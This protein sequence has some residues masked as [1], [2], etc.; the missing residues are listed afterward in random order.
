MFGPVLNDETVL[1]Q[2]LAYFKTLEVPNSNSFLGIYEDNN[3]PGFNALE[4]PSHSATSDLPAQPGSSRTLHSSPIV[5]FARGSDF[6]HSDSTRGT[7]TGTCVQHKPG[8]PPHPVVHDFNAL[9]QS[10]FILPGEAHSPYRSILPTPSPVTSIPTGHPSSGL[11]HSQQLPP[12]SLSHPPSSCFVKNTFDGRN[13]KYDIR[14]NLDGEFSMDCASNLLGPTTEV[15]RFAEIGQ[16]FNSTEPRFGMVHIPLESTR[17]TSEDDTSPLHIGALKIGHSNRQSGSISAD[18]RAAKLPS[19][20]SDPAA[21]EKTRASSRRVRKR[22]RSRS[23]AKM[24]DEVRAAHSNS[25]FFIK[26]SPKSHTPTFKVAHSPRETMT[27]LPASS[28]TAYIK[29]VPKLDVAVKLPSPVLRSPSPQTNE[30]DD[31]DADYEDE[32]RGTE[33]SWGTID[34]EEMASG[35]EL[36][37]KSDDSESDLERNSGPPLVSRVNLSRKARNAIRTRDCSYVVLLEM[38]KKD[39]WDLK[40]RKRVVDLGQRSKEL[41][42]RLLAWGPVMVENDI[43]ACHCGKSYTTRSNWRRHIRDSHGPKA[44]TQ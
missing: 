25:Q 17:D 16:S 42:D 36:D 21:S 43:Y 18:R 41:K 33:A 38:R 19:G 23:Y 3:R 37:Y 9:V 27:S 35:Q 7:S 30:S 14:T 15:S 39:M 10:S 4:S 31:G 24:S 6:D 2:V 34:F 44:Q 20:L 5:S 29:Q 8:S 1:S 12:S 22:S 28:T 11:T 40:T 13:A 32:D 26:I